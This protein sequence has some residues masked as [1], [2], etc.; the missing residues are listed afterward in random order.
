MI[1]IIIYILLKIQLNAY[2][3]FFVIRQPQYRPYY[4][5]PSCI[6]R[7]YTYIVATTPY[8]ESAG[9]PRRRAVSHIT[10]RSFV[11]FRR[12]GIIIV[13]YIIIH[14]IILYMI[15]Y[16]FKLR[17]QVLKSINLNPSL[18]KIFKLKND[19][20]CNLDNRKQIQ[21]RCINYKHNCYKSCRIK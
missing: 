9:A 2:I 1:I 16:L 7:T 6:E 3:I 8:C 5:L 20:P 17:N 15:S 10:Q 19:F 13:L 14:N 12:D 21:T 11:S 4:C 18:M